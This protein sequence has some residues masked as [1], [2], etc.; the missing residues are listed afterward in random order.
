MAFLIAES[1][2]ETN[3]LIN[4]LFSS[5]VHD[6][7]ISLRFFGSIHRPETRQL[8]FLVSEPMHPYGSDPQSRLDKKSQSHQTFQDMGRASGYLGLISFQS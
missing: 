7:R 1:L 8:F 2:G 4:R 3:W 5:S 6:E